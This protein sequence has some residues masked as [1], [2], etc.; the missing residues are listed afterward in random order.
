MV[1]GLVVLGS[2][3]AVLWRRDRGVHW[4]TFASLLA[5]E[6]TVVAL[7]AVRTFVALRSIGYAVGIGPAVGIS[8]SAVLAA[9][10]GIAPAGLGI[11]E[12][13]AGGLAAA[14]GV[15]AAVAIAASAVDRVAS[16]VGVLL[17]S[18]MSG[19]R[20]ADLRGPAQ[21]AKADSVV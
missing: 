15:P 19:V 11:R 9:A 4:A 6:M 7:S 20:W 17:V 10:V 1:L 12:T 18:A 2:A 16:Q 13:F 21:P 14:F 8:A 3:V 5:V